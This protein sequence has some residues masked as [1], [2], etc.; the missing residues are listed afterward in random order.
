[1]SLAANCFKLTA[2]VWDGRGLYQI[3]REGSLYEVIAYLVK[4]LMK[5]ERYKRTVVLGREAWGF[6]GILADEPQVIVITKQHAEDC[7][8]DLLLTYGPEATREDEEEAREYYWSDYRPPKV[9]VTESP[10][11]IHAIVIQ[12]DKDEEAGVEG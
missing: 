9:F 2:V 8:S 3:H 11:K 1:M 7:V 4:M 5:N 12:S 10:S 6:E